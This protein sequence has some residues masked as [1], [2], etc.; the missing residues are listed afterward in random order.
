MPRNLDK[1]MKPPR[2]D[3]KGNLRKPETI[4]IQIF[5]AP[6]FNP[7]GQAQFDL[8]VGAAK[9]VKMR[10]DGRYGDTVS[11]RPLAPSMVNHKGLPGKKRNSRRKRCSGSKWN[12]N[13]GDKEYNDK[14]FRRV[15]KGRNRL[16][17]KLI[18]GTLSDSEFR[19]LQKIQAEIHNQW[20]DYQAEIVKNDNQLIHSQL[21]KRI[22]QTL[23]N[24][25]KWMEFEEIIPNEN[26]Q[27]K[28]LEILEDWA[29]RK[30]VEKNTMGGVLSYRKLN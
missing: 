21:C 2:V 4:D 26:F 22:L 3:S 14:K 9:T 17:V 30:K 7:E 13:M 12:Y 25:R 20:M 29:V 5:E 27:G 10:F 16:M 11:P 19:S 18:W 15:M 28:A 6:L 8:A 1:Q 24:S 23:K